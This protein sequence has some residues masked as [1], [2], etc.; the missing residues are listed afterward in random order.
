MPLFGSQLVNTGSKTPYSDATQ[1]RGIEKYFFASQLY[2]FP[3]PS[4]IIAPTS[5]S[6]PSIGKGFRVFLLDLCN[7]LRDER[8][9]TFERKRR[10]S[11]FRCYVHGSRMSFIRI[12]F[13][14]KKI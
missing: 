3:F 10:K 4:I 1:V 13:F 9:E 12:F 11:E 6:L 7:I 5:S 8:R 14:I 2:F